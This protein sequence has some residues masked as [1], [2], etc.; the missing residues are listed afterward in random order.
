MLFAVLMPCLWKS[1]QPQLENSPPLCSSGAKRYEN[2]LFFGCR[3]DSKTSAN[4]MVAARKKAFQRGSIWVAERNPK[5]P[6]LTSSVEDVIGSHLNA[7]SRSFLS[8]T[9]RPN[10]VSESS[11]NQ[12]FSIGVG[13]TSVSPNDAM[14]FIANFRLESFIAMS[15]TCQLNNRK[16]ITKK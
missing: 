5:C 12:C 1:R 8:F 10:T 15:R 6:T 16:G 2:T 4:S 14:F 9:S 11:A 7:A 3:F 13:K